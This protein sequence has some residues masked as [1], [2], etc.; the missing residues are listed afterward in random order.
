MWVPG[1]IHWLH[2]NNS[3]NRFISSV[4]VGY[5]LTYFAEFKKIYI[6]EGDYN[7]K[8]FIDQHI[9]PQS[10]IFLQNPTL[11]RLYVSITYI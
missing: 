8:D 9:N 2:T 10:H 6:N 11:V 1:N 5:I 4:G 7:T 3:V